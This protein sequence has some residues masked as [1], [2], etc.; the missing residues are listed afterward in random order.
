MQYCNEFLERWKGYKKHM[1]TY[2][3]DGNID[4]TPMGFPIPQ[5]QW[6]RV[7]LVTH[8]ESTFYV[9]DCHKSMWTHKSNKAT[10]Q[11]KGE[12]PSIMILDFQ[13]V[14]WGRLKGDVECMKSLC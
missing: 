7:V 10:P 2:D 1:V 3:D 12:G 9:N 4:S 5:G 14:N 11:S 6:F 8:D 13:T